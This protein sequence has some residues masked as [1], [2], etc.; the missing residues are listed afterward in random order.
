[1]VGFL[2]RRIGIVDH[3]AILGAIFREREAVKFVG[4]ADFEVA[5]LDLGAAVGDDITALHILSADETVVV[6]QVKQH[7]RQRDHCHDDDQFNDFFFRQ[8]GL[9]LFSLAITL[10]RCA[11]F[12]HSV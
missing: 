5:I 2:I 1:M 11:L 3:S 12:C 9:L 8:K 6:E 7:N 4:F 10:V